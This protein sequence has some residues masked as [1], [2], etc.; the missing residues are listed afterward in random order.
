MK[1]LPHQLRALK[2]YKQVHQIKKDAFEN[3]KKQ[4][5]FEKLDEAY[6]DL[7]KKNKIDLKTAHILKM[8]FKNSS[9]MRVDNPMFNGAMLTLDK[10]IQILETDGKNNED[11]RTLLT[12]STDGDLYRN[13]KN[14]YCYSMKS[15][16]KR[17]KILETLGDDYIKTNKI[18][19]KIESTSNEAVRKAVGIINKKSKYRLKLKQPLIESKLGCGYRINGLYKLKK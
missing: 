6:Q 4:G 16:G 5:F 1:I 14:K 19:E 10:I 9:D 13:P 18:K 12:L 7:F 11:N 17:L 3:L 8:L 15:E 2:I